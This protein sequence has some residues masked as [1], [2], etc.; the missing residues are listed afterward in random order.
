MPKAGHS[1]VHHSSMWIMPIRVSSP[2]PKTYT[3]V[4]TG[5]FWVSYKNFHLKYW[6]FFFLVC[7]LWYEQ[8]YS[9]YPILEQYFNSK[10]EWI[11]PYHLCFYSQ[12][13]KMQR[14]DILIPAYLQ[15]WTSL[16][17]TQR[18]SLKIVLLSQVLCQSLCCDLAWWLV[19]CHIRTACCLPSKGLFVFMMS[20]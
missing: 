15:L 10:W 18:F 14:K 11:Q 3:C 17:R 9:N 19:F 7:F 8:L 1:G 6:G 13:R 12:K 2:G 20:R 4:K 5:T 16:L